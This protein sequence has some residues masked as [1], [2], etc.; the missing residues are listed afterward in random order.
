[1]SIKKWPKNAL[2]WFFMTGFWIFFY[3]GS[4]YVGFTFA[5]DTTLIRLEMTEIWPR[6]VEQAFLPPPLNLQ[7]RTPLDRVKVPIFLIL[8][9]LSSSFNMLVQMCASFRNHGIKPQI[10]LLPPELLPPS[11][12]SE[13]FNCSLQNNNMFITQKGKKLRVLHFLELVKLKR[14]SFGS[15][16]QDLANFGLTILISSL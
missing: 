11:L 2:S 4:H 8:V 16:G 12:L 6:Y 15:Q 9:W 10:L 7:L 5:F 14:K 3:I 13:I 1:M